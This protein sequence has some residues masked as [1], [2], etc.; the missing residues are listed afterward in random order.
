MLIHAALRREECD[1]LCVSVANLIFVQSRPGERGEGL[2]EP[3]VL[4]GEEADPVRSGEKAAA[5]GWSG[6]KEPEMNVT[7]QSNKKLQLRAT[8]FITNSRR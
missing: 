6:C 7:L 3:S 1:S 5:A 2:S 4:L 8:Q